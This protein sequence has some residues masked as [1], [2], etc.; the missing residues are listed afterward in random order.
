MHA[1][2]ILTLLLAT[3]AALNI[4][5]AA[6]ITARRAGATTAQ[7]ILTA[8]GAASTALAIFFAAVAAFHG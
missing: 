3:S 4:A 7:A 8:G 1:L 2:Q 5:F 6:G